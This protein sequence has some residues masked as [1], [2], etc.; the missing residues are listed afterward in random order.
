MK[1]IILSRVS[2]AAQNLDRQTKDLSIYAQHHGYQE[3]IVIE[4]KES[5]IKLSEDERTVYR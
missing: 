3:L 4:Y 5:A 1:A 2:T